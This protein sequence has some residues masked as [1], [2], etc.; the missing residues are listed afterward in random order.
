MPNFKP[1]LAATVENEQQIQFPLFASPKLDGIRAL[2]T[3]TNLLSRSLKPIPNNHIQSAYKSAILSHPELV[4]LDG[5]LTIG[6]SPGYEA[7]YLDCKLRHTL[8]LA[9]DYNQ[10]QSAIMAQASIPLT[11]YFNVFDDYANI[12]L[13]FSKRLLD[14]KARLNRDL[15]AF[16]EPLRPGLKSAHPD[17]NPTF[18]VVIVPQVLLRNLTELVDYEVHCLARG[19]EGVMLRS[20]SAP[21]KYGRSTIRQFYLA[22][23]KRFVDSEALLVDLEEQQEN[24]NQ[25]TVGELGQTKRSSHKANKVGKNT[26]GVLICEHPTFGQ[27]RIGTGRGLDDQLRK[28]MWTNP[29]E[30]IGHQVKF[31]YQECGTLDKPRIPIFLGMRSPEDL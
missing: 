25:A 30:Y 4:G 10:N 28:Q 18:N 11:T 12:E 8:G 24:Q 3:S 15:I 20:P 21:Y 7:Q 5:E 2:A 17:W 27:I 14:I 13:P 1:T 22:K 29:E 16:S 23:L 9:G 19:Y 31:K 26:T 6:P